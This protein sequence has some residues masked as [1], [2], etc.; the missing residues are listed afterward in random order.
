MQGH[1]H[2]RLYIETVTRWRHNTDRYL[3]N[4]MFR[5]RR[6]HVVTVV[7]LS[8]L[9]SGL[10]GAVPPRQIRQKHGTPAR[11]GMRRS[12]IQLGSHKHLVWC[13]LDLP[14]MHGTTWKPRDV[15]YQNPKLHASV[16]LVVS[17]LCPC[18]RPSILQIHLHSP[19]A[20]KRQTF[21]SRSSS[22]TTSFTIHFSVSK[23][24]KRN[25]AI[26]VSSVCVIL[27]LTLRAE[28]HPTELPNLIH[29]PLDQHIITGRSPH[30]VHLRT[31]THT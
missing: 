23:W 31:L 30:S 22:Q 15:C 28:P 6:D 4:V 2:H 17:S 21:E 10:L 8:A 5:M 27:P 16:F 18:T 3:Q 20:S 25:Y 29:T 12:Q 1:Q 26:L 19:P 11:L 9:A 13:N 24:M 14:F 7:F